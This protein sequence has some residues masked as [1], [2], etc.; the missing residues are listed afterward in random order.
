MNP[1]VLKITQLYVDYN[2]N[3]ITLGELHDG[4]DAVITE[5]RMDE[6]NNCQEVVN[7]LTNQ[8]M[9]LL[10]FSMRTA[11]LKETKQ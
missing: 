5:E 7:Y 8:K 10:R 11:Q 9:D 4:V 6:R 2:A 3:K 1:N